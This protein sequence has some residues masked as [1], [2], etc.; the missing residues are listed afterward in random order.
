MAISSASNIRPNE[1]VILN[2]PDVERGIDVVCIIG[3]SDVVVDAPGIVGPVVG[4][5]VVGVTGEV[6]GPVVVVVV[7]GLLGGKVEVGVVGVVGI[8]VVVVGIV[9]TV[10]TVGIGVVVV[11]G[12]GANVNTGGNV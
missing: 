9:G 2:E 6:A 11:P 7:V 1:K 10:G 8:A 3:A 4:L 12:T 5:L